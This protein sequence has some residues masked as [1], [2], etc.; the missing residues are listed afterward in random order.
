MAKELIVAVFDSVD[1]AGRAGRDFQNFAEKDIGF[2]IE[3]G[4]L[5]QK[6]ASG[7]LTVLEKESRSFWGT[8]IGAITGGLIGLLGGPVGAALGFAVGG[9][10]LAEH[11]IR[12]MFDDDVVAAI[13]AKLASGSVAFIL[14]AQ[15]ASPFEVDNIVKG[16]GGSVFRKAYG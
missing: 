7:K 12:K 1:I 9:G 15:E 11:E 8:A 13:S 6:D 2:K 10:A 5:V 3:S 16:Y 14:E 4:V